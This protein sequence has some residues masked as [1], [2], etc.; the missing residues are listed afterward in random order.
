MQDYQFGPLCRLSDYRKT[1]RITPHERLK[2][3]AETRIR[4]TMIGSISAVEE[5]FGFLW[6][7]GKQSALTDQESIMDQLR[8]ELRTAILNLGNGQIRASRLDFDTF[9]S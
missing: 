9:Y 1:R 4:T 3:N 5:I 6:G 8:D 2:Q 7:Q